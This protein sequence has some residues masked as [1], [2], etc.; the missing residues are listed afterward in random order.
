M[1]AAGDANGWLGEIRPPG[2][3]DADGVAELVAEFAQSFAFSRERFQVSYPALLADDA[4]VR[5]GRAGYPPGGAVLP[6]PGV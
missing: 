1:G 4:G 3:G 2:V 5:A 6:R